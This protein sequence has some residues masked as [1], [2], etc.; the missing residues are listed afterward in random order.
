VS[1]NHRYP[2]NKASQHPPRTNFGS[3]QFK[4]AL[5]LAFRSSSWQNF[6]SLIDSH[7]VFWLSTERC[8]ADYIIGRYSATTVSAL[9]AESPATK[10]LVYIHKW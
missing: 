10:Y 6:K 1:V 9:R 4:L 8:R 2:L 3:T 5:T 7:R